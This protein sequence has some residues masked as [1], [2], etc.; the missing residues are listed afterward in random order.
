M[1]RHFG[2]L[3]SAEAEVD[4]PSV[5]P[6]HYVLVP[7]RRQ[8]GQATR[9]AIG[10]RRGHGA[11]LYGQYVSHL[12]KW[13]LPRNPGL[14]PWSPGCGAHLCDGHIRGQRRSLTERAA[15]VPAFRVINPHS[16]SDAGVP[17]HVYP[18]H[19][20]HSEG[21]SG[22]RAALHLPVVRVYPNGLRERPAAII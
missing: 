2:D 10:S 7:I 8:R 21:G 9:Y 13:V 11:V 19:F 14:V 3:V 15:A 6:D 17:G 22:V 4:C 12:T 18:L 5:S 1:V 16:A 20:V